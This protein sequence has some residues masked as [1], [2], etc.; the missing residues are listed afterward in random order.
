VLLFAGDSSS[1]YSLW[2]IRSGR[3]Q[4]RCSSAQERSNLCQR[5]AQDQ[6]KEVGAEGDRGKGRGSPEFVDVVGSTG[7]A[8]GSSSGSLVAERLRERVRVQE[9]VEAPL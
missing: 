7:G 4:T 6:G 1:E 8:S 3:R 5:G 2:T 9:G